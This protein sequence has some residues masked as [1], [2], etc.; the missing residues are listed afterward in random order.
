MTNLHHGISNTRI[1]VWVILHSVSYDIGYFIVTTIVQLFHRVH[2]TT[3]Y[4]LKT[5][6]NSRYSTLQNYIR[7]IVQKP[8]FVHSGYFGNRIFGVFIIFIKMIP[9]ERNDVIKAFFVF[10][11]RYIQR[12]IVLVFVWNDVI[13]FFVFHFFVAL[14]FT[15]F[16]TKF[17]KVFNYNFTLCY[18]LLKVFH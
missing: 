12:I 15:K 11:C 2:N 17:H 3:L 18:L 14:S 6:F 13:F 16:Y 10:I 7:S 9:T 1:S 5:V 4:W 8:V